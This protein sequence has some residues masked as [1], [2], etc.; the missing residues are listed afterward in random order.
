MYIAKKILNPSD[1]VIWIEMSENNSECAC[2]PKRSTNTV[3]RKGNFI[4]NY[5]YSKFAIPVNPLKKEN[6]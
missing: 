5:N 1:A 2:R 6:K 4:S 3:M